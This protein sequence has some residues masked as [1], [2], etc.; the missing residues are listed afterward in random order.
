MHKTN[1]GLGGGTDNWIQV[2]WL[3]G[4]PVSPQHFAQ[5][6][7]THSRGPHRHWDSYESFLFFSIG[8]APGSEGSQV[9]AWPAPH[10][11]QL[12]IWH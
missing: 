12:L 2:V 7:G 9:N 8:G 10:A 5:V 3:Q 11:G 1:Q 4:L 6:S